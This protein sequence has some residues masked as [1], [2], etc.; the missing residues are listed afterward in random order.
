MVSGGGR[1]SSKEEQKE[2][3]SGGPEVP[4]GCQTH[5]REREEQVQPAGSPKWHRW[6]E[7]GCPLAAEKATTA[8]VAQCGFLLASFLE[9]GAFLGGATGDILPG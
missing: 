1:G 2:L 5:D 4:S 9:T 8:H 6:V 7:H 3:W